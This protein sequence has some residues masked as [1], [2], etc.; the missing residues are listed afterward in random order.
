MSFPLKTRYG[1][2][3]R[4][5]SPSEVY[6]YL[7]SSF[8]YSDWNLASFGLKMSQ[9]MTPALAKAHPSAKPGLRGLGMP[10]M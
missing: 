9:T 10:Q 7:F 4:L 1:G 3:K 8:P 2:G 6:P 5:R